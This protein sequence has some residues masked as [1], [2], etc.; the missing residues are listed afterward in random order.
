MLKLSHTSLIVI[1]GL[2]WL[3]VGCVLLPL[4]LNFIVDGVL[5]ENFNAS[6]HPI[7]DFFIPIA[8]GV[9]QAAL[10]LIACALAIG[11]M[12]GRYVFG[13]SVQRSVTRILT[14]PNPESILKLYSFPY[15]MLLGSMFLLGYIVKFLPLDVRGCV[16]VVIGSALINGAVLFFRQAWAVKERSNQ[17]L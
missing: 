6:T 5:K 10:L 13:K 17:A 15:L 14:L 7:L 8:G 4:G 3:I 9:E 16:D 2:I 12:K 11:F 1:S